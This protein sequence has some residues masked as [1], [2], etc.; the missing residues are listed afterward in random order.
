MWVANEG[1]ALYNT[2]LLIFVVG[3][4][5]TLTKFPSITHVYLSPFVISTKFGA[6]PPVI[7]LLISRYVP[8]ELAGKSKANDCWLEKSNVRGYTNLYSPKRTFALEVCVLT[9]KV[10]S[11]L[12]VI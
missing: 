2:H 11:S 8:A 7:K 1:S 10:R 6:Y 4:N 5:L 3:N 12:L 9:L